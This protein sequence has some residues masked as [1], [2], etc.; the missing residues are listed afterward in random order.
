LGVQFLQ[1]ASVFSQ[2]IIYVSHQIG[3]IAVEPVVVADA[4]LIGAKLLVGP[5]NNF[6]STLQTF[7]FHVQSDFSF[8][9][10]ESKGKN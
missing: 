3:F 2:G 9:L 8:L 5:T 4:A 10:I 7:F 6:F 1:Y